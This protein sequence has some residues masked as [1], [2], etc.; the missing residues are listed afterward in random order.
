MDGHQT[1]FDYGENVFRPTCG[2]GEFRGSTR[3]QS[4]TGIRITS[5]GCTRCSTISARENCG[6]ERCRRQRLFDLSWS[7]QRVSAFGWFERTM[8]LRLNLEACRWKV[9]SPPAAWVTSSQP[10]NNDSLVLRFRYRDS[11]AL[12]EGDAE[13]VVEQ[14]LV[15]THNLQADL[16]KGRASREQHQLDS[17]TFERGPSALGDYFSGSK[18]Y[19]WTSADRNPEAPWKGWAQPPIA[20]TGTVR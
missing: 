3:W 20:P 4:P 19:L 9:L 10:R 5:A 8:A 2:S 15:A 17:G 18:K 7:T 13:R 11:R 14:R 12:L 16:L 6:S 1:E